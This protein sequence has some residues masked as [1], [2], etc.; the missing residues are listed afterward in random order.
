M[1]LKMSWNLF[2]RAVYMHN[3]LQSLKAWL[4][5]GNHLSISMLVIFEI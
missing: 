4:E 5:E 3:C 1:T 2:V